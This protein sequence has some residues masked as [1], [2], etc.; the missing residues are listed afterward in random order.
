MKAY[1]AWNKRTI[2][3]TVIISPKGVLAAHFPKVNPRKHVDEVK[4]KLVELQKK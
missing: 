1:G 2:R 3:S 4:A